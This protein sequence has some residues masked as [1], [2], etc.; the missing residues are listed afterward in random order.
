MKLKLKFFSIILM[1]CVFFFS[2][3][4]FAEVERQQVNNG[5]FIDAYYIGKVQFNQFGVL[6]TRQFDARIII[7]GSKISGQLYAPNIYTPL[8]LTGSRRGN[9]CTVETTRG[10]RLAGRCDESGFEA[11]VSIFGVQFN[12]QL[13]RNRVRMS[14]VRFSPFNPA[15][16]AKPFRAQA[17]LGTPIAP[18]SSQG[19]SAK[20]PKD[21]EIRTTAL[22]ALDEVLFPTESDLDA[23]TAVY[24]ECNFESFT[25]RLANGAFKIFSGL[26]P[27]FIDPFVEG[28]LPPEY[29]NLGPDYSNISSADALQEPQIWRLISAYV[30]FD[31]LEEY[32]RRIQGTPLSS[33]INIALIAPLPNANGFRVGSPVDSKLQ[34]ILTEQDLNRV[35]PLVKGARIKVVRALLWQYEQM[36]NAPEFSIDHC[37]KFGA[38]QRALGYAPEFRP[39]LNGSKSATELF[40]IYNEEFRRLALPQLLKGYSRVTDHTLLVNDVTGSWTP[41]VYQSIPSYACVRDATGFVLYTASNVAKERREEKLELARVAFEN[42]SR[43]QAESARAA[44]VRNTRAASGNFAPIDDD[45][46]RAVIDA[47]KNAIA[48]EIDTGKAILGRE[49]ISYKYNYETGYY[50][51][52]LMGIQE[53]SITHQIRNTRCTKITNQPIF[54][55]CNYEMQANISASVFGMTAPVIRSQFRPHSEKVRFVNGAWSIDGLTERYALDRR[56]RGSSPSFDHSKGIK[57][58]H[59]ISSNN[60][61]DQFGLVRDLDCL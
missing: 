20:C 46:L 45:I 51:E 35:R 30:V 23:V 10:D 39:E 36:K 3:F 37:R 18:Y 22:G 41:A 60:F 55:N 32:F 33:D 59:C 58:F 28:A 19:R 56:S 53:L 42:E 40:S 6:R 61:A 7:E 5:P 1:A 47:R 26:K 48:K 27:Y 8:Q 11:D 43:R 9:L 29:A 34:T 4:S 54:Y 31:Q 21:L 14:T 38:A 25:I 15:E 50:W 17:Y 2:N 57:E 13:Y 52:Q 49:F 44:A 16:R 24:S 12:D